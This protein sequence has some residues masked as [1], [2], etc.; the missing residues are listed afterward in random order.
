MKTTPYWWEQA[1]RPETQTVELPSSIDVAVIG[2]GFTGL[3]AALTLARGGASVV[4]FEAEVLGSGASTRNGGMVGPSFHKLGI[5]GLKRKYGDERA[6]AILRESVRFVD[7]LE[8]FLVAEGIDADFVRS[9]RFRGALKP[10]HYDAMAR[11][12]ESLQKTC[13]VEGTMIAKSEQHLETGSPAFHGGVVYNRDGGLHPA[14][15]HNALVQRV[16]DAG[17]LIASETAVVGLEKTAPGFSVNTLRGS[18]VASQVAVCTNGYTGP[19]TQDLRRR[20][21]PLRSA[22]VA[23]SPLEPE[24][25]AGLMPKKRIY[26]DSRRVIAYYRP[27]PDGSRILFGGRASGLSDNPA[28]NARILRG[29]MTDVYP[30]LSDVAL[31]HVWSG[32]VAYTFDHAPHIGQ[33]GGGKQDGMYYAVGYCG[34]GVARSTYFGTKLGLKMLGARNSETAFDDLEFEQRPFYNGNPWFMPAILSWHRLAEKIGL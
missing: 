25:M 15:Y 23:T 9:G 21:I 30:Q 18:L 8:G 32:L 14:K 13:G 31:H 24:L 10:K 34:S 33:F 26:S 5:V 16:R 19:V 22:M 7:Y 1:P 12:L 17:V 3:C 29:F 2:A 4:V 6:N 27:S 11:D 20:L 28:S